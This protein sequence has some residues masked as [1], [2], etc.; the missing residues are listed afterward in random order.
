MVC[1]GGMVVE[2]GRKKWQGWSE[3]MGLG[4]ML[5]FVYFIFYFNLFNKMNKKINV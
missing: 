2:G 5:L 3:K 1:D 4:V